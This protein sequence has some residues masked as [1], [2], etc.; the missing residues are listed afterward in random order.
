MDHKFNDRY[1][2]KRHIVRSQIEKSKRPCKAG[3]RD[4]ACTSQESSITKRRK[5]KFPPTA[6]IESAALLTP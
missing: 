6:I 4:C 2:Y 5:K 3:R 1:P